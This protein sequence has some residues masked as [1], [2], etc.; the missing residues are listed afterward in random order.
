RTDDGFIVL[1][2]GL[3]PE[4]RA[5]VRVHRVKSNH[6]TAKEVVERLPMEEDDEEAEDPAED[7]EI[8]AGEDDDRRSG[9]PELGSREDFWGS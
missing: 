8:E 3:L 4:A 6:A 9:R 1:V 7:G 2:D 5:T